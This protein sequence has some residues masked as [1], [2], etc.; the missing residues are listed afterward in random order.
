MNAREIGAPPPDYY[1]VNG[2]GNVS[3]ADALQ[4][5]NR[6]GADAEGEQIDG[7]VAFGI[8]SSFV[9]GSTSGLPIRNL[10]LVESSQDANPVD[11]LL[12]AGFEIASG[13]TEDAVAAVSDTEERSS[14]SPDSVD[15]ALSLLFD[16]IGGE[17]LTELREG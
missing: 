12:S 7:S 17:D 16:D 13:A 1:D 11:Q 4:V 9:S 10:E 6:L 5:I 15:E 2:N 14:S 3:A 8:T